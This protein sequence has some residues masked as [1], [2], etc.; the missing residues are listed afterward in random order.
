MTL[1]SSIKA[2]V[3]FIYYKLLRKNIP[4]TDHVVRYLRPSDVDSGTVIATGFAYK[5]NNVT[6]ELKEKELSVNWFEFFSKS[7][8]TEDGI[9]NVREVFRKKSYSLKENGRFARL[10]VKALC[11]LV[12]E[13]TSEHTELVS[14]K[15]KH[16]PYINDLSHS[17]I[18]GI[19][20][21]SDGEFL[22]AT[23]L[24]NYANELEL[25]PALNVKK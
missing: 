19:P 12:E 7:D 11:A 1:F 10:N 14:L 22:V 8:S 4:E 13:G 15:T 5:K 17:S 3:I 23:I 18:Y 6:G 25:F 9:E 2:Q 20:F 16:T 24:A 21:D